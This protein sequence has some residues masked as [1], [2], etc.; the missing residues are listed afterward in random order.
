MPI[1]MALFNTKTSIMKSMIRIWFPVILGLQGTKIDYSHAA[2]IFLDQIIDFQ[3]EHRVKLTEA[4][5]T[6]SGGGGLHVTLVKGCGLLPSKST[7]LYLRNNYQKDKDG[8]ETY[9][10]IK[11]VFDLDPVKD[12]L[13]K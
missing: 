8:L 1:N 5:L 3:Y 4:N 11:D 10:K 12:L 7:E 9:Y 13:K 2:V 6:R